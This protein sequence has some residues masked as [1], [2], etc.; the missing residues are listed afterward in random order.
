MITDSNSPYYP[1]AK[2]LTISAGSYQI[3]YD[4]WELKGL[5]W[6]KNDPIGDG[7]NRFWIRWRIV[8][9]FASLPQF[10]Q[11]KLHSSRTELNNDGWIE[12]F[13]RARPIATLPWSFTQLGKN[14][15][16]GNGDVYMS[17]NIFVNFA[18]NVWDTNGDKTGFLAPIPLDCDTSTSINVRWA[19][20]PA[21]TGTAS[22][23]VRWVYSTGGDLIYIAPAGAPTS[24]DNEQLTTVSGATVEGQMKWFETRIDVSDMRSRR[25][26]SFPDTLWVSI[27][28][29]TA[30]GN[31]RGFVLDPEYTQWSQGGHIDP[32]F[33]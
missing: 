1:H 32:T 22:W 19:V 24:A 2:D 16:M 13:G 6:G 26:G 8:S 14:T 15:S 7:N 21:A 5:R 25:Q 9:P 29:T 31:L 10:D 28:R 18:N 17:D 27:E 30:S 12:Y 11:V 20:R 23:T 33:D 4:N 3:R